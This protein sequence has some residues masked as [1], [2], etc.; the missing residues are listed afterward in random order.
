[1]SKKINHKHDAQPE[2]ESRLI[3]E[4]GNY[5]LSLLE[6][7]GVLYYVIASND[8]DDTLK[9]WSK[10]TQSTFTARANAHLTSVRARMQDLIDD[11]YQPHLFDDD[12]QKG[13]K[14]EKI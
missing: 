9:R 10:L 6:S 7:D 11:I 1:M 5:V 2:L 12:E 14:N 13:L 4:V 8:L 3:D